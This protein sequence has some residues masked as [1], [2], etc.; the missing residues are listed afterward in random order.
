MN[1]VFTQ[2]TSSLLATNTLTTFSDKIKYKNVWLHLF[3]INPQITVAVVYLRTC[4][5]TFRYGSM[6]LPYMINDMFKLRNLQEIWSF[7][8]GMRRWFG[9][10]WIRQFV[11][12]FV[13]PDISKA[14][15][16]VETSRTT[17]PVT[18]SRI[19]EVP[20]PHFHWQ[21]PKQKYYLCST[22][23]VLQEVTVL[24][25]IGAPSEHTKF[26]FLPF[27]NDKPHVYFYFKS[28][29]KPLNRNMS[30]RM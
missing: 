16:S 7:H 15:R 27:N 22:A 23:T 6:R 10:F 28:T 8:S 14:V 24:Y 25:I 12:W 3:S 5:W 30:P 2:V 20:N 29:S 13:V 17:N 19:Q 21:L 1:I 11:A 18:H 9:S 4:T 26:M